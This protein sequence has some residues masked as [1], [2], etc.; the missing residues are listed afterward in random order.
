MALV[1]A[2]R[3]GFRP[4]AAKVA[5]PSATRLQRR[6]SHFWIIPG[7]TQN[8]SSER[9]IW[10]SVKALFNRIRKVGIVQATLDFNKMSEFQFG[11]T[12]GTLRGVDRYGNHYYENLDM[13]WG[14]HRWVEY[15]AR[16]QDMDASQ[17]PPEWHGW[18]HYTTRRIPGD[19]G[20]P[21]TPRWQ[22]LHQENAT[23]T[24]NRYMPR[25][26]GAKFY[27]AP[28]E[29]WDFQAAKKRGEYT[30]IAN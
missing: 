19:Y 21:K 13:Q 9:E 10:L 29:T 23:M 6:E 8:L 15:A 22:L 18:L 3:R 4:H 1:S 25:N 30:K 5:L 17:V 7:G 26:F 12:T 24:D 20:F 27:K 2:T 14:R 11:E 28:Y 16:K